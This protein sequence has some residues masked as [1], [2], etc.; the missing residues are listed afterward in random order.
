MQKFWIFV[1][2]MIVFLTL[3]FSAAFCAEVTVEWDANTQPDI[4]EYKVYVGFLPE[5]VAYT[6]SVSTSTSLLLTDI[7]KN[8]W[9]GVKAFDN[10]KRPSDYSNIVNYVAPVKPCEGDFDGDGDID[11]G[12]LMTFVADY[13]RTNCEQLPVCEGDF[14]GDNKVDNNELNIFLADYGRT[15]C[16]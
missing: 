9:I 5:K 15:N 11:Y 3:L 8:C 16:P 4:K 12:E 1:G 14:N 10:Q 13:G 2:F 7:T 6:T